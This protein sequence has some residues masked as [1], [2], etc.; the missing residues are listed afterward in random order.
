[1]QGDKDSPVNPGANIQ[2]LV[3]KVFAYFALICRGFNAFYAEP[4]KLELEKQIWCK[5]FADNGVSSD[6]QIERG[7]SRLL[8]NSHVNPPQLGVFMAWMR[9]TPQELGIPD[10]EAAYR[11]CLKN[12]HPPAYGETKTWSHEAVRTAYMK[13]GDTYTWRNNNG[14][15]HKVIFKKHYEEAVN[16]ALEA[17]NRKGLTHD[18]DDHGQRP[19]TVFPIHELSGLE[20]AIED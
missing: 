2:N 17:E 16:A 13:S 18:K 5:A 7:I 11:E 1:M 10:S 15:K 14:E 6:D 8:L 20:R 19:G 4:G 12:M 9:K 3:N